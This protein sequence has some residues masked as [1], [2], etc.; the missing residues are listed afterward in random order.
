MSE[1][2]WSRYEE[3]DEAVQEI[4]ETME[5]EGSLTREIVT[6]YQRRMAGSSH[7][8]INYFYNRLEMES[9]GAL[10]FFLDGYLHEKY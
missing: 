4:R 1:Q 10:I 5:G 6:K 8:L 3:V 9:P 7:S 2:G